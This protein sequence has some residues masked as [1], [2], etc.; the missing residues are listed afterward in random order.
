MFNI[1]PKRAYAL[2]ESICK[3]HPPKEC[4]DEELEWIIN[5]TMHFWNINHCIERN[6]RRGIN[7]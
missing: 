7:D 3:S 1:N 5:N 6:R 4:S 2:S